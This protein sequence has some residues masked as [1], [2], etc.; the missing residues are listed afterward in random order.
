MRAALRPL[1]IG[2]AVLGLAAA[3]ASTAQAG[4]HGPSKSTTTTTETSWV[5][6]WT[7]KS[8]DIS[9]SIV[10]GPMLNGDTEINVGNK[11]LTDD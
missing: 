7:D 2:L 6:D 5:I 4:G 3:G 8:L 11:A 10:F 9:R 1:V